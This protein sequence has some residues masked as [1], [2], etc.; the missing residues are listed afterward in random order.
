MVP[1]AGNHEQEIPG[2]ADEVERLAAKYRGR[3]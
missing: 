3:L 1:L 2:L